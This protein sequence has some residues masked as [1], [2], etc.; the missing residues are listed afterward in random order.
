MRVL[1]PST[2]HYLGVFLPLNTW[3]W[4]MLGNILLTAG[5]MVV[6]SGHFALASLW[7]SGVDPNG[8]NK[9][10]VDG[11]YRYSRNPMYLGVAAAQLGFFLALPSVFS[12][13]C[14]VIGL[15]ALYRQVLVEEAHLAAVFQQHYTQYKQ[16]VPRWL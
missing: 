1:M 13:V 7:R 9:L 16:Q 10:K 14:L 8:P 2:D 5:F 4:V 12:L 11:L 6:M 3:P 15:V